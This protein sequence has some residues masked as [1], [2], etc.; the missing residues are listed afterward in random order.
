MNRL[1]IK[2]LAL[3][4]SIVASIGTIEAQKTLSTV[5]LDAGHGGKDPG[6]LGKKSKE[7]DIV[8]DFT[9]RLGK[10]LNDSFPD[11]KTVYTRDKDVFI[12]LNER[13]AIA[14]KNNADLFISVHANWVKNKQI[15]GAET[16]VLGLHRSKENLEVAQKENS[17]IVMED[18]Y[19]NTYEGFDPSQPE[20]YI[21]FS[22]MQNLY[23]EQS[24]SVASKIQEAF[25]AHQRFDRG[26]KQAGFL[27]LRQTS[28]PSV[29]IELG[30][31]SNE[32]EEQYLMSDK[33]KDELVLSVF[34]AF[35][36][37]KSQYDEGNKA[38]IKTH[39]PEEQ[40]LEP[41][42]VKGI[43]FKIQFMA[44]KAKL[45]NPDDSFGKVE[46]LE[47]DGKFKY[48]TGSSA[49]YAD[50][51]AIQKKMRKKYPDCFIVAFED[52]KKVSVK[53]AKKMSEKK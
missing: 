4:I 49:K 16:F 11:V 36:A 50:A 41:E 22:L 1:T 43:Y 33:G 13:A 51:A 7:K 17:V 15:H 29:L 19:T 44:S 37:Y 25:S 3:I 5:V 24:I 42:D 53:H 8:L 21:I 10:M 26:V 28:M 30:F 35:R 40:Q 45:D 34:N 9:L 52:G 14:N 2:Y 12:P 39:Q 18:D 23:L 48:L 32:T 6:A 47:E 20:S 38:A 46:I 27:V 31:I